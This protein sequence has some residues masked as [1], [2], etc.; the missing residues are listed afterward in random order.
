MQGS[1]YIPLVS[2]LVPKG[3]IPKGFD[4]RFPI[5][6]KSF[7]W[8]QSINVHPKDFNPK[9]C[10]RKKKP[11]GF[12]SIEVPIQKVPKGFNARFPYIPLASP[13]VWLHRRALPADPKKRPQGFQKVSNGFNRWICS[14]PKGF[15]PKGFIKVPIQKVAKVSMQGSDTFLVD[16]FQGFNRPPIPKFQWTAPKSQRFPTV[17]IWYCSQTFHKPW[18]SLIAISTSAKS[19]KPPFPKFS[20]CKMC[21][22]QSNLECSI[23][24]TTMFPLNTK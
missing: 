18:L 2:P 4:A 14:H 13:L 10:N 24:S 8:F 19:N 5:H 7:Q 15:N 20:V 21:M 23:E 17:P 16:R 22:M 1:P 11:K 9:G 3:S 12:Q 6:S